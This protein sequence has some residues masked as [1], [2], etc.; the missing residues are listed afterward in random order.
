V[1]AKH[2]SKPTPE[3]RLF[4][5]LVCGHVQATRKSYPTACTACGF[6]NRGQPDSVIGKRRERWERKQPGTEA[7]DQNDEHK[8]LTD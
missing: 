4:T 7:P 3:T 5:C 6:V 2:V 1:T 8:T